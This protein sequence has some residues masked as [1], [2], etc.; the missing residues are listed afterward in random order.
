MNQYYVILSE[1]I[2][3][4]FEIIFTYY[5]SKKHI[6]ICYGDYT[7]L[8]PFIYGDHHVTNMGLFMM[9]YMF[10]AEL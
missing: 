7:F 5:K 9:I 4:Y 2:L 6:I 1:P 8:L 10:H 3:N